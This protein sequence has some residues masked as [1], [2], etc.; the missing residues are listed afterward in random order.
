LKQKSSRI[1]SYMIFNIINAIS[2]WLILYYSKRNYKNGKFHKLIHY[3]VYRVT[4]LKAFFCLFFSSWTHCIN[5]V[6]WRKGVRIAGVTNKSVTNIQGLRLRR[7]DQG[8]RAQCWFNI[9][10][11]IKLWPVTMLPACSPGFECIAWCLRG[12]HAML[13]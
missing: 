12:H 9:T 8:Q 5:F 4:S 1:Y 3:F 13:G 11:F 2:L 6:A 7:L 10:W